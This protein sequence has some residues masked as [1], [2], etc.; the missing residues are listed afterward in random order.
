MK[1]LDAA[2]IWHELLYGCQR[3]PPSRK[4]E[5]LETYL[6]QVLQPNLAI[7]PLR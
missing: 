4:R 1:G 6:Y 5:V 3:L 2:P 7:Y